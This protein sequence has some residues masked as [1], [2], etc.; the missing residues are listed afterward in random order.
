M[1]ERSVRAG[2]L[3]TTPVDKRRPRDIDRGQQHHST[4]QECWRDTFGATF[5]SASVPRTDNYRPFH[6]FPLP[7]T[8]V[9]A[10]TAPV[11]KEGRSERELRPEPRYTSRVQ[12]LPP[13]SA[14]FRGSRRRSMKNQEYAFPPILLVGS[15]PD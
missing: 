8:P 11:M 4:A 13:R 5:L 12:T 1:R 6:C 10:S 3:R 7:G 2:P 15:Q 14:R 9:L